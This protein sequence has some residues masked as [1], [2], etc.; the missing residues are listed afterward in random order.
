MLLTVIIMCMT[1]LD[2]VVDYAAMRLLIVNGDSDRVMERAQVGSTTCCAQLAA[3][4]TPSRNRPILDGSR[5]CDVR[6]RD[7]MR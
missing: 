5:G 2:Y 3:P 7:Y 4:R 6:W 1:A